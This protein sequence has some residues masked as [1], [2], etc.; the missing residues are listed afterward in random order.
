MGCSS[1]PDIIQDG[2]LCC[3][4]AASKRSYPGTGTTWSD[5]KG[6]NNGT[7]TNSPV[8]DTGN[9]GGFHFDSTDDYINFTSFSASMFPDGASIFAFLKLESAIPVGTTRSGIW[10]FGNGERSHYPYT[11]GLAYMTTFRNT[12]VNSISLSSSVDREK[13][14]VLCIT[15]E[16][17][18]RWKMY[19]NLEL[20]EDV[21]AESSVSLWS[22]NSSRIGSS[23]NSRGFPGTIYNVS[24]YSRALSADEIRQNYLST[25]ER[26]A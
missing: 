9:G 4:E 2:L 1:G 12:R 16:N 7:L 20:V 13:P 24:I 26:F 17:S 10:R 5:L 18:G 19:Q 6:D 22:N 15:T 11:N 25:K 14:H 21:A 23:E 3:L 8:F